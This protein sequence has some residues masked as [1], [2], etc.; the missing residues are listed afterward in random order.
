MA[1]PQP[2]QPDSAFGTATPIFAVHDL[3]K[4]ID[5]YVNVLGFTVDWTAAGPTA[6]VS[7]GRCCIFLS[8]GDQG[9]MGTWTWIGVGDVE[10]L[11]AEYKAKG[12]RMRHPPT[13]YSWAYEMQVEDLDGNV[14]RIGSDSK[15]GESFGPWL[16]MRGDRWIQS[17]GGDRTRASQ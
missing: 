1:E 2:Q 6:S 11:F 12:A 10:P 5:Y 7:R 3:S 8:Q 17:G 16:D 13:N 14:L 4:S 15:A 9:H